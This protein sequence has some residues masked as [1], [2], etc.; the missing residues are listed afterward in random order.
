MTQPRV[1]T[2]RG[3]DVRSVLLPLK[4][5][6]LMLPNAAVS[7]V[8][9]YRKPEQE[10]RPASGWFL[11]T[12]VWRQ[13]I[14]PLVSFERLLGLPAEAPSRHSRVAVCNTL[15]GNPKL[16]YIGVLLHNIPRLVR[17]SE[18][19]IAPLEPPRNL[20]IFV[21]R[22]VKI[23]GEE[24]WIPDLDALERAVQSLVGG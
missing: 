7:E 14:L 24:A 12:Q 22:Q 19:N 23:L 16:P 17:A 20:G 2:F 21:L 15:N 10:S 18:E 3:P 6:Q 5:G 9:G 11:G 13:Q 1:S 8:V 4:G